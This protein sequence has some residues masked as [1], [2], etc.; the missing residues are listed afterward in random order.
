MRQ[1]RTPYTKESKKPMTLVKITTDA[2]KVIRVEKSDDEAR[3]FA[4]CVAVHG[5]LD[6]RSASFYPPASILRIEVQSPEGVLV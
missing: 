6:L 1:P 5:Y 3:E 2:G 4:D